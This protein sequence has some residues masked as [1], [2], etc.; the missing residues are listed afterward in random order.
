MLNGEKCKA[1][2][3]FLGNFPVI[4]KKIFL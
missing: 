2:L 3:N 1:V 4:V